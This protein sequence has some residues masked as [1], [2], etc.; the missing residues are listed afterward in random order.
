MLFIA[1]GALKQFVTTYSGAVLLS[2]CSNGTSAVVRF[3]TLEPTL[4][5]LTV[6]GPQIRGAFAV[7]EDLV[8]EPLVAYDTLA[9]IV[10]MTVVMSSALIAALELLRVRST[11]LFKRIAIS[12]NIFTYS[13]RARTGAW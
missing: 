11:Y 7:A 4:W 8:L 2:M 3:A 13:E 9:V 12:T 5:P 10:A 6:M 1:F